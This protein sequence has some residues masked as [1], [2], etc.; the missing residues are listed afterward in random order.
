MTN[1][2]MLAE[3]AV[4]SAE[5]NS[6]FDKHNAVQKTL[7]AEF[8]VVVQAE[9]KKTQ[10]R[11]K[12]SFGKAAIALPNFAELKAPFVVRADAIAKEQDAESEALKKRLDKLAE[13]IEITPDMKLAEKATWTMYG[14]R[15]TGDYGSQ[16][17]GA[18][19]YAREAARGVLDHLEANGIAGE[20]RE[21]RREPNIVCGWSMSCVTFQ[22]YAACSATVCEIVRR[23]PGVS[24]VEWVRLQWKRG[25]NPRVT[26]PFL[27]PGFEEKHG[28][29]YFGGYKKE[30]VTA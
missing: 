30:A 8:E 4:K 26:N 24:L 1:Q 7:N 16:G 9:W 29:D 3:F 19:K 22:V 11:K 25:V 12:Y 14:S 13:Q 27:P 15:S 21:D 2:E 10:G 17:F 20:I 18:E 28:L 6:L 5:D 23:K